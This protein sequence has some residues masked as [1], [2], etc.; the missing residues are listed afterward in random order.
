MKPT[1]TNGSPRRQPAPD[2]TDLS[3]WLRK[4]GRPGAWITAMLLTF[5]A[6]FTL[7]TLALPKRDFSEREN[8]KLADAPKLSL[9]ALADGSFS[10]GAERWFSDRFFSRDFWIRLQLRS[11]TL[12][13]LRESGGVWLGKK[14]SLFLIPGTP[15]EEALARNL[16]AM[17]DFAAAN[18]TVRTYVAVIPNAFT[19]QPGRLPAFAPAPDQTEQLRRVAEALPHAAF[20][21]VTQALKARGDEY[22]FYR[23]DHHWTSLGAYA[24]FTAMA[25]GLGITEPVANYDTYPVSVSFYGTLASKSGRFRSPDTVEI[26]LPRT[27]VQYN[28][29]YP[30][31]MKKTAS[32]Y[33]REALDGKDQY[34]VFFGGNHPRVDISTTAGTGR[35]LLLIKD[36]YANCFVQFLYP[37]FDEI[38]MI[39]PRY[40]Y[41]NAA[42]LLTQHSVTDILYLYNC[43]T[44]LN[45][46]SLADMLG[47][48]PDAPGAEPAPA[49]EAPSGPVKEVG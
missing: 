22:L 23:T 47:I 43:D 6:V 1:Q 40:Y 33:D 8:R 28:V 32:F 46:T 38:V 26:W 4:G 21:D 27:E 9:S 41:D 10:D 7:L 49:P 25:P 44:F 45:D 31:T 19:V 18:E 17:D 37:Y 39:D 3:K 42:P 12:L 11:H 30:D 20:L 15:D 29:T 2:K 13:G 16:K 5:A 36:S 35:R 24:A 34:L 14:G 48:V